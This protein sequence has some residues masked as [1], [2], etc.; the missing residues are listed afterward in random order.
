MANKSRI[1]PFSLLASPVPCCG[2]D[3]QKSELAME[4]RLPACVTGGGIEVGGW[5]D[6]ERDK[7]EMGGGSA[8]RHAKE[9][10]LTHPLTKQQPQAP[11]TPVFNLLSSQTTR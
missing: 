9:R 6:G 2:R 3:G 4:G 7:Q 11:L 10:A 8:R 5:R 1:T